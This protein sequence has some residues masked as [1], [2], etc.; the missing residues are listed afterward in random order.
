[1]V[2]SCNSYGTWYN[3]VLD[4]SVGCSF[5]TVSAP[6]VRR[7]TL[8]AVQR[9]AGISYEIVTRRKVAGRKKAN[10]KKPAKSKSGTFKSVFSNHG[11][12]CL[13]TVVNKWSHSLTQ[14]PIKTTLCCLSSLV[15]SVCVNFCLLTVTDNSQIV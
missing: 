3:I 7:K 12:S 2:Q 5:M 11:K 15:F 9:A 6:N 8:R 13:Y 10:S 4:V 14:C 1:M